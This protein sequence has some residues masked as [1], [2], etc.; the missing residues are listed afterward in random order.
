M[1]DLE[2]ASETAN[3]ENGRL[4]A[5]VDKLSMELKEYRKRLSLNV[6]GAS[7][8]PPQSATQS[9]SQNNGNDFSFAFP[10]FGDLPGSYLNNGSLVKT[11]SPPQNGQRSAS[12]SNS[13]TQ[14]SLRK[15]SSS[16]SMTKSPTNLNGIASVTDP[17]SY[18]TPPI[19]GL[20]NG[21]FDD[22]SGL[23][24]PSIFEQANRD[25]SADYLS[26]PGSQAT[27]TNGMKDSVSSV[28]GQSQPPSMRQASFPSITG[29]PASSMSH[30]LDSSCGTTPESS[31]ESPDNRKGSENL[32]D[33]I[34]EE[35]K[36]SNQTAGKNPSF[37]RHSQKEILDLIIV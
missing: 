26:Y 22:I 32:L 23:F 5:T 12:T 16:S 19:N 15:G 14:S 7:Y 24:S 28:N 31:A 37:S 29:S 1:E 20:N 10:K 33:T 36:T 3:H 30:A 11:T 6:S 18:Q 2:K 4:R 17:K 21:G 13:T 34:N 8:S 35:A 25:S 27:P 9:K